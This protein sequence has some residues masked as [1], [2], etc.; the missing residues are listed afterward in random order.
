MP[1]IA[2][3]GAAVADARPP[4]SLRFCQLRQCGRETIHVGG[5]RIESRRHA[6]AVAALDAGAPRG[7]DAVFRQQSVDDSFVLLTRGLST[8]IRKDV[9][10]ADIPGSS[11]VKTSISLMRRPAVTQRSRR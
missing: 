6:D 11:G 7:E 2:A 10:P 5:L 9:M 1:L 8:E 4:L 3:S